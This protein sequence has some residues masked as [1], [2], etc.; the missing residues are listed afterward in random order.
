MSG[1]GAGPLN[2]THRVPAY[3]PKARGATPCR[4][5]VFGTGNPAW[6]RGIPR[7]SHSVME[8]RSKIKRCHIRHIRLDNRTANS[9][10]GGR[11]SPVAKVASMSDTPVDASQKSAWIAAGAAVV[12]AIAAI[13]V[14]LIV[15]NKIIDANA[16]NINQSDM[17]ATLGRIESNQKDLIGKTSNLEGQLT[18]QAKAIDTIN[19][20]LGTIN[21]RLVNQAE[22]IGN[23][24]GKLRSIEKSVD[25]LTGGSK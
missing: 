1:T 9:Y 8:A 10:F 6:M 12:A 13:V 7:P 21:D 25:T 11:R 22:A 23:I 18:A 3:S 4:V 14:P 17:T 16:D 5:G 19:D 2:D 15:A 24:N 20:R